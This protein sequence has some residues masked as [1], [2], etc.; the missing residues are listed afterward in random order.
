MLSLPSHA[1]IDPHIVDVLA[2]SMD[3]RH[4]EPLPPLRRSN[5]IAVL[6]L[7]FF[8]LDIVQR[9]KEIRLVDLIEIPEPREKLRLVNGDTHLSSVVQAP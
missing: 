1:R 4:S 6:P 7:I 5:T 9:H 3:Y 2:E 8:E